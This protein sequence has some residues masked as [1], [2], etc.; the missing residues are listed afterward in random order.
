MNKKLITL[1]AKKNKVYKVLA[2]LLISGIIVLFNGISIIAQNG[3][4]SHIRW[5]NQYPEKKIENKPK[6]TE[7]LLDLIFGVKNNVFLS[8]PVSLY[9]KNT[10]TFIVLD[11]GIHSIMDIKNNEC[12]IPRVI[13]KH[14]PL[15]TSL[16]GV[17]TMPNNDILFTESRL[18]KIFVLSA[19]RKHLSILNDSLKLHQPTG[20]AYSDINNEIWVLETNMHRIVILDKKGKFKKTIGKRGNAKRE[21]NFPTSIWIDKAGTAYIV[22]AMNFRI[23]IFNNN[24][25]LINTFGQQGDATGYFARP[26]GIATD[27]YGN[28]YVSDALFHVVQIFDK[29]GNYLF[30]FGSQGRGQGEFWMPLGL[31]IDENNYIYVADSFNSRIQIFQLINE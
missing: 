9:A 16:V 15:L 17:C 10:N 4:L 26:K 2:C 31:Y 5:V 25:E 30:K 28:I 29:K 27:S 14:Y 23:Q 20:I 3:E 12:E 13:K 21:F 22:D 11:Q 19:D 6:F 1:I 18:N 8:K 7:R 24:G